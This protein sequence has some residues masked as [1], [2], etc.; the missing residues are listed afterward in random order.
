ML[1]TCQS[2]CFLSSLP[3]TTCTRVLPQNGFVLMCTM[4][5][6]CCRPLLVAWALD[7]LALSSLVTMF[8]FFIRYVVISDGVRAQEAGVDMDPVVGGT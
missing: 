4:A 6:L 5:F 8:P 1:K 2:C 3:H 7:G